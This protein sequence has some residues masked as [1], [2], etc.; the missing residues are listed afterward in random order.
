MTEGVAAGYL[1]CALPEHYAPEG[2]YI[3]PRMQAWGKRLLRERE[4]IWEYESLKDEVA[5][6]Q[7][8]LQRSSKP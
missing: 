5:A 8:K 6:E 1:D 2:M 4:L 7:H 3:D